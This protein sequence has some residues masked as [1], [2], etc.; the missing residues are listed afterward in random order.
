MSFE[1]KPEIKTV[2]KKMDFVNRYTMLSE[3]FRGN[4]NDVSDGLDDY[5]PEKVREI[6]T[7]LG[8]DATFDDKEKF[9]KVGVVRES[10]NYEI[11]FNMVLE[12]GITEFVWVV[13][14]DFEVRLGSPWSTYPRFLI[15]SDARIKNPVYRS[16]EELEEIL[17]K[18][19][20]MYEDF[21]RHLIHLYSD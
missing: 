9:F 15:N 5:D 12:Y 21:K 14:H 11:W 19:L 3:Q 13:F 4:S 10:S 1:M 2:L 8:Y 18:A 6:L 7:H 16:Y 20:I 17:E